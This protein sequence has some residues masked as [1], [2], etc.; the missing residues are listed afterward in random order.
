MAN[1]DSQISHAVKA[2]GVEDPKPRR[3]RVQRISPT[4]RSIDRN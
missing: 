3:R 2:Y 4:S 1:N